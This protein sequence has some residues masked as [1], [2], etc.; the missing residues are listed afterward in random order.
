MPVLQRCLLSAVLLIFVG[1]TS[2]AGK[3]GKG[4][5]EEE[6]SPENLL[7][8]MQYLIQKKEYYRARSELKRLEV[9]YAGYVSSDAVFVTGL[10]L[11]MQGAQY[12][13]FGN[14]RYRGSNARISRAEKAYRFDAFL[15]SDRYAL[16]DELLA[17]HERESGVIEG[18]FYLW[19]RNFVRHLIMGRFDLSE[20]LLSEPVSPSGKEEEISTAKYRELARY[21]K[22]KHGETRSPGKALLAGVIPGLGYTYAGNRPTGVFAFVVVSIFSTLTYV[23][24]RTDNKPVGVILGASTA[25][26]YSGSILGGY[27]E[28]KKSNRY[29]QQNLR[30]VLME[31]ARFDED[32]ER[33][34]QK[35]G[36]MNGPGKQR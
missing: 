1:S 33:I 31:G 13:A 34:F 14:V 26:F 25:F 7:S 9:F 5:G 3:D 12:G 27:L 15:L 29:I 23:A 11:D 18:E 10:Y 20:R 36:I 32:R 17:S 22:I 35:Y 6:Y 4:G 2:L 8:F 30:D 19:K 21:A 28:A 24:F 16:A